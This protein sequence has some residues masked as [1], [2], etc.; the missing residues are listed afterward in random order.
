MVIGVINLNRIGETNLNR[1]GATSHNR[2]GEINLSKTGGISLR[3]TN[4]E[5]SLRIISK[6]RL[7]DGGIMDGV[8]MVHQEGT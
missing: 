2:T 8:K 5:I 6:V 7:Q 3:I 4:G 1:I